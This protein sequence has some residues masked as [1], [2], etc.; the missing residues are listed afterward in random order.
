MMKLLMI[1]VIEWGGVWRAKASIQ[2][3]GIL[4]ICCC[5]SYCQQLLLLNLLLLPQDGF[6][7]DLNLLS[8]QISQLLACNAMLKSKFS[9][10]PVRIVALSDQDV[11]RIA[12][13]ISDIHCNC[14]DFP[15]LQALRATSLELTWVG[16]DRVDSVVERDRILLVLNRRILA[17]PISR[18]FLTTVPYHLR[19]RWLMRNTTTTCTS[20]WLIELLS[21]LIRCI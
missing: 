17:R 8:E 9:C 5:T 11:C 10:E 12:I 2:A 20:S 4:W 7:I 1:P 6:H 3:F 13:R 14:Q 19:I 21:T 15:S 18:S 16:K